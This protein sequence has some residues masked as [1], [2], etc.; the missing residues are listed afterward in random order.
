MG[1]LDHTSCDRAVCHCWLVQ[2]CDSGTRVR[3]TGHRLTDV[4][5]LLSQTPPH[6]P[7]SLRGSRPPRA[8]H[9][10]PRAAAI[11]DCIARH[12]Q[13][14]FHPR[15]KK[16]RSNFPRFGFSKRGFCA[17]SARQNTPEHAPRLRPAIGTET[18]KKCGV[19]PAF[20]FCLRD[21][22]APKAVET[23]FRPVPQFLCDNRATKPRRVT[24]ALTPGAS[25]KGGP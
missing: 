24:G 4:S 11:Y 21:F 22:A 25:W 10:I 17:R 2:Q 16:S 8:R 23:R 15:A 19:P 20:P 18:R 6:D 9:A 5:S 13:T 12:F 7:S 3:V 1:V 14:R